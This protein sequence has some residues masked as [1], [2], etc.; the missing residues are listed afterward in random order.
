MIE[1][2]PNIP[3]IGIILN[4]LKDFIYE[5]TSNSVKEW[6]AIKKNKFNTNEIFAINKRITEH[7]IL[8]DGTLILHSKYFIEMLKDGDFKIEKSYIAV[9][10]NSNLTQI[11]KIYDSLR[12]TPKKKNRFKHYLLIC[13]IQDKVNRKTSIFDAKILNKSNKQIDYEIIYS[14]LKKKNRFS[15]CISITIPKEFDTKNIDYMYIHQDYGVYEF[16]SKIDK[17]NSKA[18][19]FSP[20]CE[21][22]EKRFEPSDC[23]NIYYQGFKWKIRNPA[24][25]EKIVFKFD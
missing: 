17:Q 4:K 25:N 11:T 6:I 7:V 5:P 21:V 16:I 12:E 24:K 3:G 14:N 1:H 20:T 18:K 9:N 2:L 8:A 13:E 19:K 15:F 23:S 22:G 10:E